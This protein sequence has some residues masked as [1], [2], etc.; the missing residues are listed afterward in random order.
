MNEAIKLMEKKDNTIA[1]LEKMYRNAIYQL[2]EKDIEEAVL[3][4]L[5]K[6]NS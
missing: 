4:K 6:N 1:M 2:E 5:H 3:N